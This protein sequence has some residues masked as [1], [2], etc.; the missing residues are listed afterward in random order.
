MK[1]FLF[2]PVIFP[3]WKS[4]VTQNIVTLWVTVIYALLSKT[5]TLE[6]RLVK[7]SFPY[8]YSQNYFQAQQRI[9]AYFMREK[10]GGNF[11]TSSYKLLRKKTTF[12]L[13]RSNLFPRRSSVPEQI[14]ECRAAHLL[15]NLVY[16]WEVKSSSSFRVELQGGI[17]LIC[18]YK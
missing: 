14:L 10:G 13:Y 15:C 7:G 1:F 2:I 5:V 9:G 16:L 11:L 6:T 4:I 17:K 8:I 12:I 18:L 3:P